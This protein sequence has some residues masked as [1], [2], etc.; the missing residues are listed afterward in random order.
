MADPG[1]T[2]GGGQG[3]GTAGDQVERRRR[4]D[5]GAAGAEGSGCGEGC[6]ILTG[7]GSGEGGD[8]RVLAASLIM[9]GAPPWI[10]Q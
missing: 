3:R 8:A 7:E 2:N 1:F 5:R 10:R 4:E 9:T 6:P